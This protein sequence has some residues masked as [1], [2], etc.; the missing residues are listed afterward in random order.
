[1]LFL[2]RSRSMGR[3]WWSF[4]WWRGRRREEEASR[5][6]TAL[7]YSS[8][9]NLHAIP[10]YFLLKHLSSPQCSC[11][12][13]A[14][15]LLLYCRFLKYDHCSIASSYCFLYVHSILYLPHCTISL[16]CYR[17]AQRRERG[18]QGLGRG[19]RARSLRWRRGACPFEEVKQGEKTHVCERDVCV[20]SS[21]SVPLSICVYLFHHVSMHLCFCPSV[22]LNACVFSTGCR[23]SFLDFWANAYTVSSLTLTL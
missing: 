3:G 18:W 22:C 10:Q 21:L 12:H 17:Q 4:R 13:H 8:S 9:S 15:S 6:V 16:L 11:K 14:P 20:S 23:S 7:L 1:M 5:W 2:T 19:W